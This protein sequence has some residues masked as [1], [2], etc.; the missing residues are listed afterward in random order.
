MVPQER[1]LYLIT[2]GGKLRA[3]GSLSSTLIEILESAHEFLF[4]IQIRERVHNAPWERASLKELEQILAEVLPLARRLDVPV[5][6]NAEAELVQELGLDGV[7]LG[8]KTASVREILR[9]NPH[10]GITGYSAHNIEEARN[11]EDQGVDFVTL[12][13]IF[14]PGSKPHADKTLGLEAIGLARK[15]LGIPVFALG[16]IGLQN[17]VECRNAGA[18]GVAVISSVFT[19]PSPRQAT[20]AL[21]EAWFSAS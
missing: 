14:Q 15:A 5:L 20:H 7:H 17:I 12:S 16:G 18:S 19:A 10:V 11:A 2:D 8:A 3:S 1:F 9:L 21:A 4:G 6:I 13:P